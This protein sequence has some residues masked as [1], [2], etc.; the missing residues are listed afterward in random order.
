[1]KSALRS[2]LEEF[3]SKLEDAASALEKYEA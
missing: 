1:L 2:S 3:E